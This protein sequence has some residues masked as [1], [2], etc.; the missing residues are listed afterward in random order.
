MWTMAFL[1]ILN[2]EVELSALLEP[3]VSKTST[4]FHPPQKKEKPR[5][6]V[7][8]VRLITIMSN[9]FLPIFSLRSLRSLEL[10]RNLAGKCYVL[11]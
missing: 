10:P 8:Y 7:H 2:T 9:F 4:F 5:Q 11:Q 6:T 3:S 1:G